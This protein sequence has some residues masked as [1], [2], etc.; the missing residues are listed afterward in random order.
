LIS[1]NWTLCQS[2][3]DAF[4]DALVALGYP[5]HWTDS[6]GSNDYDC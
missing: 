5:T 1:F 3:V 4:I 2:L 6:P